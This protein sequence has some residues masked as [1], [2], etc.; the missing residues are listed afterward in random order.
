ME[1]FF[2][3]IR[4]LHLASIKMEQ[5]EKLTENLKYMKGFGNHFISEVLEGAVPEN[6]NNPLKCPYGLIAEQL[7]G[8][9]FTKPRLSNLRRLEN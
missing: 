1:I 7:S 3:P 2:N 9:A 8:T 6:Q 5:Q 4:I